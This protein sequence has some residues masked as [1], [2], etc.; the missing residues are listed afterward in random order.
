MVSLDDTYADVWGQVP[1]RCPDELASALALADY[2]PLFDRLRQYN[3]T[4]RPPY[5]VRAMWRAVLTKYLLGIDYNV[6]LVDL[7]RSNRA[8]ADACGFGSTTPNASVVCR[9][10]KR[11][12][13]HQDLVNEAIA[14]LR[15]K[16]IDRVNACK[17]EHEPSV[18]EIVA[19]DSTDIETFVDTRRKPYTDPDARW[20]VRTPKVKKPKADG[21]KEYFFGY[22]MHTICD[23]H[24][25]I[26]LGHIILPANANDS[27]Q[28]PKVFEAM[29]ERHPNLP[30]RYAL[31]DRG[32]DAGANYRYLDDRQINPVILMR[33]T[34]KDGLYTVD[35]RPICLG[36]VAM[37]YI[38][39]D[40]Q[41]GH[42]YGCRPEGCRLKSKVMFTR[43]CDTRYYERPE[44]G[45]TEL[46]RKVGRVIPRAGRLWRRL[47]RKR[48]TIE[49]LFNSLKQSRLLNL[50]RYRRRR[51]VE[52]HAALSTH[53]YLATMLMRVQA[54]DMENLRMMRIATPTAQGLEVDTA[55]AA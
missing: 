35:G 5:S 31:A 20:G 2:E 18:G 42:L 22:K 19:I 34:D 30:L 1:E 48:Q 39:S 43:H 4:G 52:L 17:Q 51:K 36:G 11:L 14:Y 10:F 29:R 8:V 53:A 50:H 9:F 16:L 32:Y 15:D 33:N 41:R 28:L 45:D 55:M 3:C 23:A 7:L 24:F 44:P 13:H 40:P 47:Y 6:E 38:E 27:P 26:P 37:R 25:G 54:G 12:M 46:L 21:D 49:R